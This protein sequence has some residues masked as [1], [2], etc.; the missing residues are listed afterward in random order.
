MV[1]NVAIIV[2][3]QTQGKTNKKQH[4][5]FFIKLEKQGKKLNCISRPLRILHLIDNTFLNLNGT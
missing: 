1:P 2:H 5:T 3:F 4:W